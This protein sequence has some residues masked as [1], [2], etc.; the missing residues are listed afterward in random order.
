MEA[1]DLG[2]IAREMAE[3]YE[4]AAQEAG[5]AFHVEVAPAPPVRGSRALLSQAMANLLDNALKYAA[6][7]TKIVL[8]VGKAPRGGAVLSVADDGPGVPEHERAHVLKRFVRLESSRSTPGSGLGL[9][10]V[11]AIA[12]AHAAQFELSGGP[13]GGDLSGLTA[14]LV[15]PAFERS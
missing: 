9:S 6:G 7:G 5:F 3:L 10:L 1:V 11:A 8:S 12:R 14:T 4:P 15:F 13:G 2:A